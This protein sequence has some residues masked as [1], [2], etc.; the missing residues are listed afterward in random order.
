MKNE[1][2]YAVFIILIFGACNS[3]QIHHSSEKGVFWYS[4]DTSLIK[5]LQR[6]YEIDAKDS[7]GLVSIRDSIIIYPTNSVDSTI[8]NIDFVE[9]VLDTKDIEL[10]KKCK[11]KFGFKGEMICLYKMEVHL[12]K[13]T[14]NKERFKWAWIQM[15]ISVFAILV[16]IILWY[17]YKRNIADNKD[18]DIGVW[19]LSTAILFWSMIGLVRLYETDTNVTDVYIQILSTLNNFFFILSFPYFN[20]RIKIFEIDKTKY[21]VIS[22][23]IFLVALIPNIFLSINGYLQPARYIN[24]LYSIIVLII[25][26]VLFF[27][28]FK[29]RKLFGIAILSTCVL[30]IIAIV[31]VMLVVKG[32][33]Y[34]FGE[35]DQILFYISFVALLML[36]TAQIFSWYN[37]LNEREINRSFFETVDEDGKIKIVKRKKE[38]YQELITD[39]RVEPCLYNLLFEKRIEDNKELKKS[40]ILNLRNIRATL[41]ERLADKMNEDKYS[42]KRKIIINN[43]L[44]IVDIAFEDKIDSKNS[45]TT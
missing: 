10:M 38:Y 13:L 37:E 19:L 40:V 36:F 16:W 45:K 15:G 9:V 24:L 25:L 2:I 30:G 29:A 34:F 6:Q 27:R 32:G 11:K 4:K 12:C 17:L 43:V 23:I 35:L 28:S 21:W 8:Q 20:H 33:N 7:I 14:G 3:T 39:D 42:W 5:E 44:D 18:T 41:F 31:Q 1:I 22:I 26:G